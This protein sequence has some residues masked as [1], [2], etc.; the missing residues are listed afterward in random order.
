VQF[1]L[2]IPVC[3]DT[4]DKSSRH[5]SSDELRWK[6]PAL[7]N[8]VTPDVTASSTF[9]TSVCGMM[10]EIIE[11]LYPPERM[12]RYVRKTCSSLSTREHCHSSLAALP[13]CPRHGQGSTGRTFRRS[14]PSP[15]GGHSRLSTSYFRWASSP[16]CSAAF[17]QAHIKVKV[18]EIRVIQIRTARCEQ[19]S[20]H[21][22]TDALRFKMVG[23]LSIVAFPYTSRSMDT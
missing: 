3:L 6:S 21:S 23:F 2:P 12:E 17:G 15:P 7:S 5:S 16:I 4:C 20:H 19:S 8:S 11:N 13:A 14:C 22:P 10:Q 18:V 9:V 1:G